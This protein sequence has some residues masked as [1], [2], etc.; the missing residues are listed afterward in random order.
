M[1]NVDIIDYVEWPAIDVGMGKQLYGFTLYILAYFVNS[2]IPEI[3]KAYFIV[4]D[5]DYDENH[6][7]EIN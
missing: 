3:D 6:K 7:N 4:K 5:I 1:K 2:L